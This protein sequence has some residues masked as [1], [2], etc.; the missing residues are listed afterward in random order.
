MIQRDVAYFARQGPLERRRVIPT[1][2]QLLAISEQRFVI[3]RGIS[4]VFAAYRAAPPDRLWPR[5]RISY[6]QAF[7]PDGTR[8]DDYPELEV[9]MKLFCDLKFLEVIRIM[10]GVEVTKIEPERE[11]RYDYLEGAVTMGWN[12]VCFE[13]DGP[14]RTR[15]RHYSEYRG[16]SWR[17]RLLM[18]LLQPYLHVGFVNALHRN[19]KTLIEGGLL[20]RSPIAR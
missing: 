5:E 15:V 2:G 10:V 6:R 9:G 11:I 7:L 17:D 19:M 13:P 20:T 3:E 8:R 4:D 12:S 16:T 1:A 18:P 14:A